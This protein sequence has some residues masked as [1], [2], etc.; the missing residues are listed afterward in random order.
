MSD[1]D[2]QVGRFVSLSEL[3]RELKAKLDAVKSE[4]IAL[5][6]AILDHWSNNGITAQRVK[7]MTVYPQRR[8]YASAPIE[9]IEAAGLHELVG[10]NSQRLSAY[11]REC[12]Q[13]DTPLP[14][15]L[16]DAVTLTEYVSLRT[17]KG[18]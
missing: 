16:A 2:E 17:R 9:A 14:Q 1:I 11:V 3:E 5:E 15:P 8:V 12:E 7:G 10:V 13:S 4:R 6:A 18:L